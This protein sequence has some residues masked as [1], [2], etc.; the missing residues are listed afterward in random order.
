MTKRSG[1]G[2]AVVALVALVG[3]PAAAQSRSSW[4]MHDGLEVS[5]SNERGLLRFTCTPSRS[6]DACEYSVVSIPGVAD[7]RWKAPPNKISLGVK[8]ASEVCHAPI[9]CQGYGD[10]THFQTLVSV[11]AALV[12]NDF[13]LTFSGLDD[14]V[15]VTIF[16]SL[17]PQGI[18]APEGFAY[19][20]GPLSTGNLAAYVKAGEVNRVVLT[21]VD[22]CCRDNVI[23]GAQLWLN[24]QV[25][26]Q[27]CESHGDCNDGNTCTADVCSASGTCSNPLLACANRQSCVPSQSLTDED[28]LSTLACTPNSSGQP[29]L[30]VHGALNMTLECGED[31][32]VDPGAQAW[33]ATCQPLM[34]RKYNSGGDAY[35]PGPNTCAEG[36]YSVQY[37][38]WDAAGRT[39]SAIRSVKV[40]D[41]KAPTLRLKGATRITHQCGKA[42]VDPGWE[43][44]DACYGNITPEVKVQGYANG[45]VKG[46][47]TLTYTLRDSGGNSAPALKRTV[48]V[49]NCPW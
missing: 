14:G 23:T 45:W 28:A 11:P 15:R 13:K 4:Q 12:V 32:W 6:G 25:V 21:H 49:V 36:T 19:I 41:T 37:I 34:V 43:A 38:A 46:T 18:T 24:N 47:Y 29:T 39:V 8:K 17:Y 1:L 40:D 16:N 2:A 33:N 44:W 10:F 22:D 27:A 31:V 3:M 48:D 26:Q 20:G 42:F 9:T 30:Q 7:S 5:P 35:G